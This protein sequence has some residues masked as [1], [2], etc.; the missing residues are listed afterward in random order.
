MTR[1]L[2]KE[3]DQGRAAACWLAS[4]LVYLLFMLSR[5]R[6]WM[7]GGEMWAE[8][9]TNYF[10]NAQA[11]SWRTWLLAT[12]AG[13]IPLPQ[14]LLAAV[15]T[16]LGISTQWVPFV[17][18]WTAAALTALAVSLF[19][20]PWFRPVMPKDAH[21]LLVCVVLGVMVD[22]ETR[23]FVN[24]TYLGA[25]VVALVSVR[26]MVV[27]RDSV[28]VWAWLLPLL[29][30][31]KPAVL[32]AVPVAML[33]AWRSP[34]RYRRIVALM[35]LMAVLQLLQIKASRA[36][37]V[38]PFQAHDATPLSVLYATAAYGLG[39]V[40]T[41]LLGPVLVLL[42]G[43]TSRWLLPLIGLACVVLLWRVHARGTV[44][45]RVLLWAGG[46]LIVMNT[47]LNCAALSSEWGPDLG[48]L[49]SPQLFRH[50]IVSFWGGLFM[51]LAC[52][53]QL[54]ERVGADTGRPKHVFVLS[55]AAWFMLSGWGSM[56]F[57]ATKELASPQLGNSQ[58][59][60]HANEIAQRRGPLCVPVDPFAWGVYGRDCDILNKEMRLKG[61]WVWQ[62]VEPQTGVTLEVPDSV[63][64]QHV[65]AM[66]LVVRPLSAPKAVVQ[67]SLQ[68]PAGLAAWASSYKSRRGGGLL[69]LS[70]ATEQP[71]VWQDKTVRLLFTEPVEV[72]RMPSAS[73]QEQ[74]AASWM[75]QRR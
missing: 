63:M 62:R 68:T 69:L 46:S 51:L 29:V 24:F 58:W 7:L 45:V 18:T 36:A 5:E 21:R 66:G 47:L 34:G 50:T 10:L 39:H 70:L 73:G 35:L 37:G 54:S 67:A 1:D 30:M 38:M 41:T 71:G 57:R 15:V 72:M 48:K 2:V 40:A 56:G 65:L 61:P 33:A 23:T 26:V 60:L 6:G 20:L 11:D 17:Y 9:A 3:P 4:V 49:L 14:R 22:F 74:W 19:A 64:G 44:V 59:Q 8:M 12:D 55:F 43:H 32:T 75:G 13:Y 25:L 52:L 31:S 27:P 42:T 16:L 53:L 28:P